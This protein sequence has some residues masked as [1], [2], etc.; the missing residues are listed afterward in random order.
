MIAFLQFLTYIELSEYPA[1]YL[2]SKVSTLEAKKK[3]PLFLLETLK[4]VS[5][6]CSGCLF[7]TFM[8]YMVHFFVSITTFLTEMEKLSYIVIC[9]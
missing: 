2:Y 1:S 5:S 3:H 9:L 8:F 7:H 4:D 6:D